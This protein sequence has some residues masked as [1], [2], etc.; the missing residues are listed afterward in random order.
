[1]HN[2]GIL[3]RVSKKIETLFFLYN[4]WIISKEF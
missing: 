2:K 1:M 4:F 3:N